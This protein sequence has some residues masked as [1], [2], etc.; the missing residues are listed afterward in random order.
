MYTFRVY[1]IQTGTP[2][3]QGRGSYQFVIKW[4]REHGPTPGDKPAK[5]IWGFSG[6]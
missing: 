5:K 2:P 6:R 1:S 3:N 4:A